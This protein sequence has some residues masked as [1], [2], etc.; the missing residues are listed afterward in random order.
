MTA[1]QRVLNDK[2]ARLIDGVSD[3][4]QAM[5]RGRRALGS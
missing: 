4:F 3:W 2:T 5:R 1:R